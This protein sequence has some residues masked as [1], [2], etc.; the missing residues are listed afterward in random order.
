MKMARPFRLTSTATPGAMA[1]VTDAK[2]VSIFASVFAEAASV[3]A[4]LPEAAPHTLSISIASHLSIA[5]NCMSTAPFSDEANFIE[6]RRQATVQP[7][8]V[9]ANAERLVY[10]GSREAALETAALPRKEK[11]FY[12]E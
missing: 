1:S 2:I 8:R 5:L 3:G 10:V 7:R 11:R 6:Y 9:R 4:S 12:G